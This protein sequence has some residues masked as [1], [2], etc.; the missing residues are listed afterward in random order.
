MFFSENDMALYATADLHLSE[1]VGKPMDKFGVQWHDHVRKIKENWCLNEDD[2]CVIAGDTSWAINLEEVEADMRLIHGLP[3]KKIILKGNHDY[4]WSTLRKINLFLKE[5]GFDDIELLQNNAFHVGDKYICGTRGWIPD[6]G[7]QEDEKIVSREAGRLKLS[8][9]AAKKLDPDAV[10]VVFLHFPPL[11]ASDR[12]AP[13]MD[14]LHEFG[15]KRVFY[16]HLHGPTAHALAVTG[17]HEGIDFKLIAGD[18]I[19]FKPIL[20]N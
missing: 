2:T 16:G 14:V 18:Y 7:T 13:I 9:S 20:I 15:I 1:S 3:G 10:P 4:W 8:I 19:G 11:F 17:I 6:V 12:C 5:K